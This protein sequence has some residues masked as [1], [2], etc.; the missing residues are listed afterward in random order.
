VI[1]ERSLEKRGKNPN[2]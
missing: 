2:L 1:R